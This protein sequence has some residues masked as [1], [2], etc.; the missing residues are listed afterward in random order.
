[1]FAVPVPRSCS[2][3]GRDLPSRC[4]ERRTPNPEPGTQHRTPNTNRAV[5][6]WKGERPYVM[7]R[8]PV[9]VIEGRSSRFRFSVLS[10]CSGAVPCSSFEYRVPVRRPEETFRVAAANA[11]PRT[12]NL[13]LSTE[14]RTRTEKRER[15]RVNGRTSWKVLVPG[16]LPAAEFVREVVITCRRQGHRRILIGCVLP[17]PAVDTRKRRRQGA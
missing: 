14:P 15:G 6:T 13:E 3:P 4:R 17:V 16:W 11:E 8:G 1:M 12:P 10:S 2:T 9:H 5:R 7:E